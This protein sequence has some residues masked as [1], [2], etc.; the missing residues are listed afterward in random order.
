MTKVPTI[1]EIVETTVR[2][3]YTPEQLERYR[4]SMEAERKQ[5]AASAIM[6]LELGFKCREQ[7]M[8][9]EAAIAKFRSL[10][11]GTN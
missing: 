11:D 1:Q 9:L 8:N 4:V 3:M 7:G 2:N 10:M 6:A 5:R